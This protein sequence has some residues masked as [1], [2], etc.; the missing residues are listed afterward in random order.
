M[1]Q[2][3]WDEASPSDSES[4]GLGDDRIRSFKTSVRIGLSAEHTW[5]SAG[6]DAGIHLLGSARAYYG[7]QSLV[8]SSGTDGRMMVTSDTSRLFGVG[9]A[10]TVMLG[11]GPFALSIGTTAGISFPQ[12]HYWAM[13]MGEVQTNSS[14]TTHVT[15]PNSGYSGVPFVFSQTTFD[16]YVVTITER[17]ATQ[18]VVKT[19]LEASTPLT[20]TVQWMSVGTRVLG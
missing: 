20:A 4:A 7:A 14:G 11:A 8:S 6:G 16:T 17:T 12:R 10:G 3:G 15:I 18:F 9:S 2:I 5:P 1:S 19:F 13:E